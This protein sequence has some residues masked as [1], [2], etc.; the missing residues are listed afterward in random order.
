MSRNISVCHHINSITLVK[1]LSQSRTALDDAWVLLCPLLTQ[2]SNVHLAKGA[3][4][5]LI[6][7]RNRIKGQKKVQIQR[8]QGFSV[9]RFLYKFIEVR[10]FMSW[11]L[12][13][14][15]IFEVKY[16]LQRNS[17]WNFPILW[18][19][20][21][22][23]S[24]TNQCHQIPRLHADVKTIFGK[25]FFRRSGFP[26]EQKYVAGIPVLSGG[27]PYPD[28]LWHYPAWI[29][30]SDGKLRHAFTYTTYWCTPLSSRQTNNNFK[31][32]KSLLA[33]NG[34]FLFLL[35][36]CCQWTL[37]LFQ[38]KLGRGAFLAP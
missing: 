3:D 28:W 4:H 22:F 17:L 33:H 9:L 27:D 16:L 26:G 1:S 30:N 18:L 25:M 34:Q 11:S 6:R 12:G 29:V 20:N 19:G 38:T 15:S 23:V 31:K 36:S 8:L 5:Q 32:K 35:R 24:L 10:Y 14:H 37:N 13:G 7:N 21:G 2:I